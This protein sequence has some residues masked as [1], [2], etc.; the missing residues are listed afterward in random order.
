MHV[1][2]IALP[3]EKPMRRM[4]RKFRSKASAFGNAKRFSCAVSVC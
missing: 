3:G 4:L 1:I 2:A